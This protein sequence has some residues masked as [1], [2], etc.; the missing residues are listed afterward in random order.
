MA[1]DLGFSEQQV[2]TALKKL[3]STGEITLKSTNRFTIA[4]VENWEMYQGDG[5]IEQPTDNQQITNKQPTDNQQITNK[6]PHLKNVKKE[7]N[8]YSVI[9]ECPTEIQAAVKDFVDMRKAIKS[10]LTV[11]AL[12]LMLKNRMT[13]KEK[14][15]GLQGMCEPVTQARL[16][17]YV[18]LQTEYYNQ[19]DRLARLENDT[20]LPARQEGDGSQASLL[21]KSRIEA[22]VIRKTQKEKLIKERI[23]EIETEMNAI[24]DAVDA[25]ADPLQKEVLRLRYLDGE[26]CRHMRWEEVA[27]ALYG[28]DDEGTKI[29]IW[30]IHKR[31]LQALD[32]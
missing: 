14:R 11:R 26:S 28:T 15:K 5:Y 10:P 8:I 18:Y 20:L 2:R 16:T 25:L 6:Q 31:A 21:K 7:R 32:N 24:E 27:I 3:E 13:P 17:N 9:A 19:I 29:R 22:A 1:S 23:A 12:E 30:R 4:T